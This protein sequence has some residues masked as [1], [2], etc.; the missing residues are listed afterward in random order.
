MTIRS[1]EFYYNKSL[2]NPLLKA[3]KPLYRVYGLV[4]AYC[5]PP[6]ISENLIEK[7]NSIYGQVNALGSYDLVE[8]DFLEKKI[9]LS[10]IAAQLIEAIH[11][12][13]VSHQN[14][15]IRR[16][17]GEKPKDIAKALNITE[18]KERKD[19]ERAKKA[20]A[21]IL[22]TIPNAYYEDLV[23]YIAPFFQHLFKNPIS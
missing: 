23:Q 21:S 14:V 10:E 2:K 4:D 19:A 1:T 18:T 6:L 16:L 12:L 11:K 5:N 17:F 8:Y 20:L 15:F 22:P 9:T 7:E 13:P 3:F